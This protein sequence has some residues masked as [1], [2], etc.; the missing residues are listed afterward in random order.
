MM[1]FSRK[2]FILGM[3]LSLITAT[4][5]SASL[6]IDSVLF[7]IGLGALTAWLFPPFVIEKEKGS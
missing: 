6:H 2:N 3:G 5:A 7:Y 1:V 4:L